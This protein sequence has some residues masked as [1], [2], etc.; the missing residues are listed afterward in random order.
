MHLLWWVVD[1]E[2]VEVEV[3]RVV[4][5]KGEQVGEEGGGGVVVAEVRL[6]VMVSQRGSKTRVIKKG[7]WA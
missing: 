3:S 7:K 4:R 1:T 2:V 6:G 5:W